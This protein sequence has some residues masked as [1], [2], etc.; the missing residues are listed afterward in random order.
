MTIKI[1]SEKIYKFLNKYYKWI[2]LAVF[3]ILLCF[4]AYF[5]YKYIYLATE[6]QLEITHKEA[7]INQL[8]LQKILDNLDLR[9]RNLLRINSTDYRDPFK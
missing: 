4:N 7:G 1:S 5:Y 6:A 2:L 9:D 8:T 3:I